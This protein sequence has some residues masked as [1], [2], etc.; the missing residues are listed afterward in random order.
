MLNGL[1]KGDS[2]RS[3][4]ISKQQKSCWRL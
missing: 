4:L 1:M 3:S 2:A